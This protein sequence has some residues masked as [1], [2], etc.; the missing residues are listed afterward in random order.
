MSF[1]RAFRLSSGGAT[2]IE[3]GLMAALVALAVVAAATVVSDDL[4]GVFDKLAGGLGTSDGNCDK[5]ND[6]LHMCR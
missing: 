4:G 3:F 6:V 1:V 5:K 2:A